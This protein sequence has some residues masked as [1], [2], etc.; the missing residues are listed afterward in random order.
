[1]Q[2]DLFISAAND[3]GT[4]QPDIQRLTAALEGIKLRSFRWKFEWMESETHTSIPVLGV[5]TGLC[6]T[7]DGWYLTDPF[8]LFDEGGLEAINK[9]FREGGKRA[10]FERPTPAF[11]ISLVVAGLMQKTQFRQGRNGV[12]ARSEGLSTSVEST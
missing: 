4:A 12:A 2:A 6:T 10:G 7:F 1:M 9:H 3:L 8:R 5:C 11:T